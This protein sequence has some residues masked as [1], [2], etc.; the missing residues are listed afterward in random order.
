MPFNTYDGGVVA[1]Q[2]TGRPLM[3]LTAKVFDAETDAPV[4]VYRDEQPITLITGAHGLLAPFQTEDTTR[5]VRLETGPVK[6]HQWCLEVVGASGDAVAELERLT[7]SHIAIDT[8][9]T[10]YYAPGSAT[11]KVG[12]DTDGT[13]FLV[14]A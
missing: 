9:G 7:V 14:L 1:D 3:G 4:Q 8:D 10:P 5:R 13:P 2:A 6:L 11:V 12:Q